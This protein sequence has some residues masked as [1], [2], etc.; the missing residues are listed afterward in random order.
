MS[1][2]LGVLAALGLLLGGSALAVHTLDDRELVI[3][4]PDAVAEGFVREVVTGRYARARTYLAEPESR[5]DEQLQAL[6]ETLGEDPTEIEA[7]LVGRN[8][9]QALA[10][11]RVSGGQGS[12]AV[13]F[14]LKFEEEWKIE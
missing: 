3:P 2:L 12:Q 5:S 7:E 11:V 1:R 8:D 9:E 14:T 13:A 6:R 4:P 10:N